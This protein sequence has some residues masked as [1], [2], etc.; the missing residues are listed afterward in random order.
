ML[1]GLFLTWIIMPGICVACQLWTQYLAIKNQP[2]VTVFYPAS[3][4][5]VANAI[6]F[7]YACA[8]PNG[9]VVC[10]MQVRPTQR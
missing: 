3:E 6:D 5:Q 10:K 7:G 9:E 4:Q 1:K 8:K 2:T